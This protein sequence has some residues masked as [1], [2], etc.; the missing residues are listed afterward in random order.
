MYSFSG[1]NG[2]GP[3]SALVLSPNGVLGTTSGGGLGEGVLFNLS[4]A[5][6]VLPSVFSNWMETLLYDFTGGSDGASP[7]GS[8]V[9]DNSGNIYGSAATRGANHGGTLYE[10]ANG[11]IQVLHAFPAFSGDGVT[12]IGVVNGS[13]GLYGI[14]SRG[15]SLWRRYLIHDSR[16][17]PSPSQLRAL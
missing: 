5:A 16:R 1:A 8:L 11:G 10:F 4:P 3:D 15:G 17:L 14:T 6:N 13:D 2:S 9:L 12:P 7:S